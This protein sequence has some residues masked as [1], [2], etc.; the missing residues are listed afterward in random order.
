MTCTED[1]TCS[2]VSGATRIQAQAAIEKGPP[3]S[4]EGSKYCK[5]SKLSR[6]DNFILKR[7]MSSDYNKEGRHGAGAAAPSVGASS[8]E[9]SY[10][11]PEQTAA[12]RAQNRMKSPKLQRELVP[13]QSQPETATAEAT[14]RSSSTLVNDRSPEGRTT[15]PN[16]PP[17]RHSPTKVTELNVFH[18]Q[19]LCEETAEAQFRR[20]NSIILKPKRKDTP[21]DPPKPGKEFM[22]QLKS[23]LQEKNKSGTTADPM[24]PGCSATVVI[25]QKKAPPPQPPEAKP[26]SSKQNHTQV[27]EDPS[28][29]DKTVAATEEPADRMLP[30]Y[31]ESVVNGVINIKIEESF[32]VATDIVQAVFQNDTNEDGY[33]CADEDVG[34]PFDW[35]FVQNWRARPSGA[36]GHVN[37]PSN[38][39]TT[40][41]SS[42]VNSS[43]G[44]L[45]NGGYNGLSPGNHYIASSNPVSSG[46]RIQSPAVATPAPRISKEVAVRPGINNGGQQ[47]DP[48]NYSL[49]PVQSLAAERGHDRVQYDQ[50]QSPPAAV[51]QHVGDDPERDVWDRTKFANGNLKQLQHSANQHGPQH[52]SGGPQTG[53]PTRSP[54]GRIRS[55]R[56]KAVQSSPVK[57]ANANN[58]K[59][60]LNATNGVL[61]SSTSSTEPLNS[62]SNS[63]SNASSVSH[64][65]QHFTQNHHA[66][67]SYHHQQSTQ[68]NSLEALPKGSGYYANPSPPRERTTSGGFSVS[69]E[70]HSSSER[71]P[72]IGS[73]FHVRTRVTEAALRSTKPSRS[74]HRATPAKIPWGGGGLEDIK[75]AIQQLTMRSHTSTSTYSSLSAGSESSEP[76]RRLGRYSSLETVN[77][78]VTSADEFV[79]VDS[80]NRLVELQHPPWSQHCVLRVLRSG[81]CREHS[82]RVSVEAVPRTGLPSASER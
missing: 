57:S 82:E 48:R 5:N 80:H 17:Q 41:T 65:K 12:A 67:Q 24:G 77:T 66:M 52:Q 14:T 36:N 54:S 40:T 6:N 42:G 51:V 16:Q 23:V 73:R 19:R 64:L 21:T 59:Q 38:G 3:P 32:K 79:W 1:C 72:I 27:V 4:Y 56:N 26:E 70:C 46:P 81:R 74:R 55:K 8:T 35:S 34:D 18:A 39:C 15:N 45:Q 43:S 53:A 29:M 9:I 50:H 49:S 28:I 71:E 61:N 60:R 11:F 62:S 7:R 31:V 63:S 78:N 44:N 2:S 10:D 76:E 22:Q 25:T 75:L 30:S 33:G 58:A 20:Q 68:Q 13:C 69:T 47:Q 37:S